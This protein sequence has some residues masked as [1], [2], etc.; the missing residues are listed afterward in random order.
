MRKL[1]WNVAGLVFV[2]IGFVGVFVPLLPT[3]V[4]LLLAAYCF[5]RG[6]EQ[7]HDWLMNH[8]QFG[9]PIRDWRQHGAIRRRAKWMAMIAIALS[10]VMSV[11]LGA[12]VW[13]LGLQAMAL[14]A[15]SVF[16]L[17]RPE[18]PAP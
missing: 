12:A 4:F 9:P 6:S 2:G 15:V 14:G 3:V 18:G 11:G 17:T 16:V 8:P 1:L 13:V 7:L 5:A 10:F